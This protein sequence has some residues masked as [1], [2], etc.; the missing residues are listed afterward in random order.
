[1]SSIWR[2][3]FLSILTLTATIFPGAQLGA[4][5]WV[6]QSNNSNPTSS[7]TLPPAE[8][9]RWQGH[10]VAL[11]ANM[12]LSAVSVGLIRAIKGESFWQGFTRGGAG[13]G[14]SYL[15]KYLATQD[16]AGAR[17]L[18]RQTSAVGASITFN[19]LTGRGTLETLSLPFG[20]FRFQHT[21]EG[22]RLTVDLV[23]VA[24]IAYALSRP[25]ARLD[26]ETSISTATIVFSADTIR[27]SKSENTVI[28]RTVGGVVI[29]HS[30]F[31]P[32]SVMR[33][34]V[35]AHEMVHVMQHDYAGITMGA[36]FE[37]WLANKLPEPL[38]K[39]LR[40]IDLG[41]YTVIELIPPVLGIDDRDTPW[42]KEAYF[43]V[44]DAEQLRGGRS[45]N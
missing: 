30:A 4:Q 22:N 25:G 28:G 45:S 13:G 19:A 43:L 29:Y 6:Q 18:G 20:P 39:P 38:A 37:G 2:P 31:T 35:L 3:T 16:F 14:I 33:D 1:M 34:L 12:A 41:T 42:E 8:T 21:P 11:G 36:A 23:T 17:L 5:T 27:R 26:L 10:A 44:D 9:P 15:G 7:S 40:Y 24:G 32:F